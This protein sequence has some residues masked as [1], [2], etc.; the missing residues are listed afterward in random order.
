MVVLQKWKLF[1]QRL[2]NNPWMN[3]SCWSGSWPVGEHACF[4]MD[5]I[6]TWAEKPGASFSSWNP[7]ETISSGEARP[8]I[9]RSASNPQEELHSTPTD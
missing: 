4:S 8:S 2:S 1:S 9:K 6:A 7:G 5:L 3:R